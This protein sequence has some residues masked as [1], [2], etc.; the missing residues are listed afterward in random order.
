MDLSFLSVLGDL[1]AFPA[2]GLL[3]FAAWLLLTGRLVTS[4]AMEREVTRVRED[5][6]AR[7]AAKDAEIDRLSVAHVAEVERAR[8]GEREWRDAWHE[9]QAIAAEVRSQNRGLVESLYFV[10]KV[11]GALPR[12]GDEDGA[13]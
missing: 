3:A 11:V 7:L 6:D 9:S 8:T 2:Y 12:P 4:S 10:R 13:S 5:R 1:G